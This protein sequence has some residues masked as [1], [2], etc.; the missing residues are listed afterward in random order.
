M[1][2]IIVNTAGGIVLA[3]D[4]PALDEGC[5]AIRVGMNGGEVTLLFR[6]GS[7]R[8]LLALEPPVLNMVREGMPARMVRMEGWSLARAS[9]IAFEL[10]A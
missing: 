10:A 8:R 7:E 1:I 9:A 2:D 6:D 3:H 4:E 5:R